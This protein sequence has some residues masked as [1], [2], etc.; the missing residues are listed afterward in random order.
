MRLTIKLTPENRDYLNT[1]DGSVSGNINTMI[2]NIRKGHCIFFADIDINMLLRAYGENVD[3][4]YFLST[5][6][7][8]QMKSVHAEL[9]RRKA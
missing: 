2:E 4:G 9:A 8:Q 5:A 3:T 7:K 6:I 1:L